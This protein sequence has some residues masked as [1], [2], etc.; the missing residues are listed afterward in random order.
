[1]SSPYRLVALVGVVLLGAAVFAIFALMRADDGPNPADDARAYLAA[2]EEGDTAAMEELVDEPPASFATLHQDIAENLRVI[3]ASYDLGAVDDD[4]DTAIAR[5]TAALQLDGLGQWDYGGTLSLVEAD[6]GWL[7]DWTPAAIHPDLGNGQTLTRSREMPPRAPILDKDERPLASMSAGRIVGLEPR[8]ITDLNQVKAALHQQLRVDPAD[9]DAALGA[10]GVQPDHF[11]PI[12]TISQAR[13]EQVEPVIYPLPGTRFRDTTLRLT[14]TPGFALHL[15]GRT[16][17]IT[18]E[19]LEELGQPYQVGDVVGLTGIESRYEGQLA[20]TPSGDIQLTAAGG[21]VV[22]VLDRIEGRKPEPVRT[23]LE[24]AAQ[25]AAESALGDTTQPAAIVVVDPEGNV[26]AAASRPLDDGFNR[27][28]GGR[29]APGSTFKVVTTAALLARGVT[30]D[31]PVECAPT[32]NAGGREFKNFES[33]S[34][35]T[36]PFG[37]A[38]AQSCNT[39]FITASADVPDADL[40]AAA[41]SFGFNAD[42]SAGLT[43]FGGSFPA[44]ADATEHAAASI[45]QGR[46]EASPLHMASVAAAVIDGTWEAPILLPDPP[47]VEPGEAADGGG[48]E[49]GSGDGESGDGQSGGGQSGGDAGS[50]DESVGEAATTTDPTATTAAGE[51]T[52][53]GAGDSEAAAGSADPTERPEPT[54]LA[55]GTADTLYSL[56]RRVVSEGSGQSAAVSGVEIAGKTGT[57]E[58]G[59]GDP[60]PTHAW[61]IGIRGDYAVSVLV[62]GGGVGGRVAAPVAGRVMAGLSGG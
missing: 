50:G 8:A 43:T 19:R 29:Y 30:P 12:I 9:I 51:S 31:T 27:A 41:E 23:T 22:E 44:P 55:P 35:G 56:M 34:L 38:F 52:D 28:I 10:P 25:S 11:V 58:F 40:V 1:M 45:G 61:F 20:G 26:R 47:T 49:S 33:S 24:L 6:D 14:P 32:T 48:A 59:S 36:V 2:W 18:A 16:G 62:E 13:Y 60:L 39:A 21:E 15:L 54:T 53:A 7:V 17:E 57:A 37:L 42:Y 3:D 5:F 46:V 4:G